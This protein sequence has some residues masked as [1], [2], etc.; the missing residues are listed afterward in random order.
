MLKRSLAITIPSVRPSIVC[1]TP[2]G[3]VTKRIKL[4]SPG[5]HYQ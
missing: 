4:R 2:R 3:I 5:L 1:H